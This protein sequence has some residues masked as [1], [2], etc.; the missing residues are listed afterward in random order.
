MSLGRTLT[1]VSV[2]NMTGVLILA[3]SRGVADCDRY[4]HRHRGSVERHGHEE[5]N[6]DTG[7]SVPQEPRS[8]PARDIAQSL[9]AGI[10]GG[11]V[12]AEG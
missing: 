1:G 4:D 7:P 12:G 6:P 11:R 2:A 3:M 9:S 5:P 10:D 8:C